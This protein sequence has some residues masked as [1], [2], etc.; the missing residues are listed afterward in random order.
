MLD[1]IGDY[2]DANVGAL[3][4]GTNLFL[5]RMP[6]TPENAVAVYEPSSAPPSYSL[7]GSG[8]PDLERPRIQI[9]VRNTVY[10][11]GRSLAYTIW[12]AMNQIVSETLGT[13]YWL[14]VE[15]VDSPHFLMRDA[16]DRP[17]FNMNFQGLKEPAA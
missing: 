5:G 17:I 13:T 10:A 9:H 11:T 14:R 2:L 4:L 7:G 12:V 1:E 8:V 6:E 15:S 3:T 16:N